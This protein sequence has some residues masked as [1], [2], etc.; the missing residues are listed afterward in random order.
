[1][2][3]GIRSFA[4][5]TGWI[6]IG[7]SLSGC[8]SSNTSD[9]EQFV[10]EVRSRQPSKIEPLPEFKPYETFLYQAGDL[11]SPFDPGLGGQA[12]QNVAGAASNN[13]LHPDAN[14]PRE[15]LEEFP[16][17]TLRMVGTLSQHGQ[18]WGLVLANDGTIHRVQPGNYL[19]QNHGK[20]KQVSEFEIELLEIVP[21]GLGG[22]MERPASLALSE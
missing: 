9:L 15:P 20:I 10:A 1:M 8:G 11:R 17:D 12:D 22:W 5:I 3:L 13:G 2:N 7:L 21:D 4:G 19:G 16:L 18:S 14:R 6:V